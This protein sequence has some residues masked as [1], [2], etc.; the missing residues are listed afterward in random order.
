MGTGKTTVGRALAA[1]LNTSFMDLDNEIELAA[2]RTI[3][4]IFEHDGE[5]AFRQL[6]SDALRMAVGQAPGVLALGG[7]TIHRQRNLDFVEK[8]TRLVVLLLPLPAIME[9]LGSQDTGR[10]LLAS[11]EALFVARQP[12]LEGAGIGVN[13]H[14]L[15]LEEAVSAILKAVS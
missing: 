8:C 15:S 9:R 7:G 11:A 1:R 6:E 5:T 4:E 3:P 13:V 10:P 14:G 12:V 2:G